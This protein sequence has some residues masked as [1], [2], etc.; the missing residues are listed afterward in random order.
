MSPAPRRVAHNGREV[1]V[2][3]VLL[4]LSVLLLPVLLVA[5]YALYIRP[6]VGIDHFAWPMRPLINSMM[7][8]ATYLGGASFFVI[9]LISRRWRHVRLGLLPISA[10]AATLGL[11]TLIHW[12][13]FVHERWA[14]WVWTG[15][16][17]GV[18]VI[19]PILWFRNNRFA[20]GEPPI[21]E[22]ELS[23]RVR[24]LF[25]VVG[26]VLS[27]AALLLFVMPE[28]MIATWPWTLTPLT[29][30]V[31]AALFIL[32]GLVGLAIC[33]DGSW[34]SARHLLTVQALTIVLMLG[35][36]VVARADLDWSAPA[37]WTFVAG[38]SAI[39]LLIGY[40][41]FDMRTR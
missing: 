28:V 5:G 18:P 24:R 25:G 13:V 26:A 22:G 11:A 8:G 35:G 29:A 2:Q 32:P 27:V 9:V 16:Y 10:F 3:L 17:V 34:A 1:P 39:L 15:L 37:S 4:V 23:P 12:G 30:R 21:R 7:L 31:M 20:D 6:D 36:I 38:M 40:T 19:L 33:L 41:R 14:F